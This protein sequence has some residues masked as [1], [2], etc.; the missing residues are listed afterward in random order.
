MTLLLISLF[1]LGYALIALEHP[2]RLSKSAVALTLGGLLWTLLAVV[3]GSPVT[4]VSH[5]LESRLVDIAGIVFFLMGAMT[6][7]E[8]TDAH[9]GFEIITSRLTTRSKRRLL[10]TI[11]LAAFFLSAVLDNMTTAIIFVTL[12][13]K[14]LKD[15]SDRLV[16]AAMVVVA[17]NAGGAWSPIGDVTTTML[18]LGGQITP[19]NIIRSLFFPSLVHL[20]IPLAILSFQVRGDLPAISLGPGRSKGPGSHFERTLMFA[21]CV[22]GLLLVPVFKTATH[23]PPWLGMLFVLGLV[24]LAGELLH[25]KKDPDAR[26]PLTLA[27]ALGRIDMASITFFVGILLAVGALSVSGILPAWAGKLGEVLPHP[28]PLALALGLVSA[29]VDNIPL[30][31]AT[32]GMYPLSAVPTDHLLWEFLAYTTGTGGSILIIGS[33]AGVAAMG[34]EKIPFMTWMRRFSPVILLAYFGGAAAFLLQNLLFR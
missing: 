11:S 21:L 7:V 23:L 20:L 30:V 12:L 13:R 16:F 9:G 24:W 29:V 14:L 18:W 26:E 5:A 8:V 27:R 28:A 19:W 3:P 25:R 34:I 15:A 31:A 4:G 1:A 17:A 10:W 32:M 2:L 6:L 22:G 33:A